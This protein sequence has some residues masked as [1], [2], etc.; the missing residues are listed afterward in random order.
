MEIVAGYKSHLRPQADQL[1]DRVEVQDEV[2][3]QGDAPAL[4]QAH[5]SVVLGNL[6]AAKLERRIRH[7]ERAAAILD[8]LFDG[9][10]FRLLIVAR[11]AGHNK[12]RTFTWNFRLLQ[13]VD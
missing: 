2:L 5:K 9:I 12:H 7:E 8:V 4:E 3:I 1:P 10:H 11:R 6:G 13:K